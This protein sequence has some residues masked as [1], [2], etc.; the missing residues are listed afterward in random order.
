MGDKIKPWGG[1]FKE[2][3]DKQVELFT[4]SLHHDRRLY[5]YD[6]EGSI[7]H[8]KMLVRQKIISPKEGKDIIRGLND[9]RQDIDAGRFI[10][11]HED[12]DIH[13]A[14]E[15]ALI[16]KTGEIGGKLHTGRSRNDQVALDVRMYVRDAIKDMRYA[17]EILKSTLV[18]LA[19]AEKNTILPGYTHLQKAQPVLLGHYFLAYWEM[20]N[21][22]ADRLRDC[23]R[24]VNVMPLGAAALAGTSLPIDRSFVAKLLRFPAITDNSMDTVSDRDYIA[25]LIFDLS[26]I[27]MHM[28]RLCED[29]ILWSTDE[30][31]YM[32]I[33]DAFTT[34]SSIMPQKKNP[35]VAELIRGKTGR[36]YGDLTAILTILKGLPMTYNRDLQEDKE[37][38]FDAIDTVNTSLSVLAAMLKG[39]S[40]NRERMKTEAGLG[41]S[42]ATDVAEYLVGQGVPFR[43]AH[44]I[45]GRLIAYCIK[46]KSSLF[47]ITL[48]EY[49][50]FY[51]G[52]EAD[53]FEVIT[54]EHSVNA[55]KSAGGTAETNVLKKISELEGA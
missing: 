55:K 37:P 23:L 9:I 32:E 31:Q 42:T 21:R 54:V 11:S 52:F 28:S 43:E 35:D 1:R 7:A 16:R 18:D 24:R 53:I 13:M 46:K 10:F 27:M 3:T 33:A 36:V 51:P 44:G 49:R 5:E 8:A 20:F 14:I 6:I 47:D 39:I 48:E 29:M 2:P 45:V 19:G 17:L 15:K 12:E 41:F 25:E 4:T 22:D 50:S 26:L 38:L 34:G 40:F 30:F